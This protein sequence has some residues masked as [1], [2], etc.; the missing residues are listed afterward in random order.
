MAA[1]EANAISR[2]S[3][4]LAAIRPGIVG[5]SVSFPILHCHGVL[6]NARIARRSR[7]IGA[8]MR[9]ENL[10]TAASPENV[11][12][13]M[14]FATLKRRVARHKKY[15]APKM[16]QVTPKSVVTSDECAGRFGAHAKQARGMTAAQNRSQSLAQKKIKNPKRTPSKTIMN[17][18]A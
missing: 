17:R 5:I 3:A 6:R 1:H 8:S 10:L 4:A 15:T 18:A 16:K 11:K 9:A 13:P 14:R 12:R 7:K 2:R